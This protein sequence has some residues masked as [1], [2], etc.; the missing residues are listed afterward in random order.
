MKHKY[1]VDKNLK[2]VSLNLAKSLLYHYE[3]V[4]VVFSHLFLHV[5]LTIIHVRSKGPRHQELMQL[6]RYE[7]IEVINSFMSLIMFFVLKSMLIR[8]A[9]LTTIS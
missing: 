3:K 4:N 5:L 2:K 6:L 8:K 9:G 1:S 7:L